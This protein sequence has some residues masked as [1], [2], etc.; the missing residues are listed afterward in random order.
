MTKS[1]RPAGTNT[2]V[3]SVAVCLSVWTVACA[4]RPARQS[5]SVAAAADLRFALD[6]MTQQ[7]RGAHS[8]IDVHVAYGSSG[9]FFAQIRNQAPFD[10]FLSADVDYPRHLLAAGIGVRDSLFVY[11]VGRIVVW[12]P[13]SSSLDPATVLPSGNV[14]HLA[15]AN[16]QHA[17]Y[18]RAA[19]AALHSLRVYD[20]LKQKLVLGENITQTLEFVQ[21]GGADAGILALSLAIA[22]PVRAQGRYWELPAGSYPKIEQG[23]LLL[24]DSPAARVFTAWIR[25]P[26]G[27][28]VLQQYGFE[29]PAN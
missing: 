26:E 21:S 16:P 12:V 9:N 25:S 18:G 5:V 15:I 22:P 11:A 29:R 8:N 4:S 13:A 23:A 10:L 14:R 2:L 19:E 24:K 27:A 28:R 20:R 17:P 6:A 1:A 7:F 3:A